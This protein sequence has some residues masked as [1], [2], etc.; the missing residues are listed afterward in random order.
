MARS[1][2]G[3]RGAWSLGPARWATVRCSPIPAG[4][5]CAISSIKGQAPRRL[6]ALRAERYGRTRR[7]MVRRWRPIGESRIHAVCMSGQGR[8][9]RSYPCH[10]ASRTAPPGCRSCSRKLNPR[11]HE[12]I[13]CFFAKT[14]VPV[15]I[16]TSF[17]DSEPIVCTPPT[18]SSR[19]A[20]AALT[21]CLWMMWFW[22]RGP[23]LVVFH[24]RWLKWPVAVATG[25]K[26]LFD[27]FNDAVG[28]GIDENRAAIDHRVA[29][30]MHAIFRWH[31]VIGYPIAGQVC[32][33]PQFAIVGV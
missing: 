2:P 15:V 9:A 32:A 19:F 28:A 7:R 8:S 33:H 5:T 10:R 22:W 16:N 12:L 13:S 23:D 30:V 17:N 4:P 29:I 21:R 31:I 20:S 14:G 27:D 25:L 3:F 18:R 24:F 26:T 1:S 6:P 11:F